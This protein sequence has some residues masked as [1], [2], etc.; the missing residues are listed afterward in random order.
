MLRDRLL[1]RARHSFLRPLVIAAIYALLAF[2]WLSQPVFH[3]PDRMV[4]D[5]NP[6]VTTDYYHFHWNYWW[7]RHAL[8]NGLNAYETHYVFAPHTSSLALHTLTPFWYPIWALLEPTFG[9]ITA[10]LGVYF[11]ALVLNG[12]VFHT[13]LEEQGT[14]AALALVGGVLL[15]GS[16]LM[17]ESLRWTMVNLMGWFWI[18]LVI[19]LWMRVARRPSGRLVWSGLL[20]VTL[21][22]MI[23]TDLQYALF[24][25][26]TFMPIVVWTLAKATT[27]WESGR[28]AALG[29]AAVLL[30]LFLLS[31]TGTLQAVLAFDRSV[32]ATTPADRAPALSF[33]EAYFLRLAQGIS[34]GILV[35]PLFVA[36]IVLFAARQRNGYRTLLRPLQAPSAVWLI[37]SIAPL[38]LS[39]GDK[40][41]ILGYEIPMPYFVLHD[42]LGGTFRYPERF[43]NLFIIVGLAFAMPEIGLWVERLRKTQQR[44]IFQLGAALLLLISLVDV[45]IFQSLPT[46]PVPTRYGFYEVMGEE[47][48]DYVVLEIPTAGASGEGLVGQTDWAATQFYGVTHGKRMINGHLSRV[49]PWRYLYMETEDPMLAWM[50]QR[51]YLDEEAVRAQLAERIHAFPIG[52]IVIHTQWLPQNGPTLQEIVGFLNAQIDLVCPFWIEGDALVYRTSWHPGGCPT[53]IPA[54]LSDGSY[55]IDIGSIYDQRFIG[56]GWH[57]RED[58]GGTT[59]RWTG[60]YPRLGGERVPDGGFLHSD[61]YLELPTGVYTLRL[62]AQAFAET[63]AITLTQDGMLLGTAKVEAGSL[64]EFSFSLTSAGGLMNIRLV[65]DAVLTPAF[66]GQGDDRRRLAVAVDYLR[67]EPND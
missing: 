46:Q 59:W 4:G 45:R 16:A 35:M 51:R 53:R 1:G 18:P 67:F 42:L 23:L 22:A 49:D 13:F 55:E 12:F 8:T 30:A 24:L 66:V 43:A 27:W 26:I 2:M 58:V 38:I 15:Q 29:L 47:A 10:M 36:G 41:T 40:L 63:R 17:V 14:P 32:L 64:Q 20:G 44:H 56:W 54:I 39:T 48:Y 33:P 9:T 57:W 25:G 7:I 65:Y 6:T 5:P 37:A 19:L 50:G 60:D 11:I 62:G 34:L 61:L 31:A 3:A 21:W 28:V 52:Y